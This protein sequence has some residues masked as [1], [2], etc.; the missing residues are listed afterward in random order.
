MRYKLSYFLLLGLMAALSAC[1]AG[2]H[3]GP[4]G[5]GVHVQ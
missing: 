3:L 1:A 4:V 5:G 2:G